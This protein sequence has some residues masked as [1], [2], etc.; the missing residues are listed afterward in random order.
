MDFLIITGRTGLRR[1]SDNWRAF[2]TVRR[3]YAGQPAW[4]RARGGPERDR[5]EQVWRRA[6]HRCASYRKALRDYAAASA[7]QCR[8][9]S[10]GR[11]SNRVGRAD[12]SSTDSSRT[13]SAH[14]DSRAVAHTT[15]RRRASQALHS[16]RRK[17]RGISAGR[18][19]V[20]P[21]R[22]HAPAALRPRDPDQPGWCQYRGEHSA[23]VRRLQ[24]CQGCEAEVNGVPARG[25]FS[26]R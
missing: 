17:D 11:E 15:P 22:L 4:R 3:V 21:V 23:P 26:T 18:R 24:P 16:A 20:P 10:P 14:A 9:R 2:C 1:V 25:Y 5:C 12:S 6:H 8:G 13:D 19:S 7:A